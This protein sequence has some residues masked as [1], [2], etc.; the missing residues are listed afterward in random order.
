[1]DPEVL[2]DCTGTQQLYSSG[3]HLRPVRLPPPS[4]AGGLIRDFPRNV[5]GPWRVPPAFRGRG[6]FQ[7]VKRHC[8]SSRCTEDAGQLLLNLRPRLVQVNASHLSV[9][10]KKSKS[11]ITMMIDRWI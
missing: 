1:M 11:I 5:A 9:M 6:R 8:Y 4:L 3:R 7:Y 10:T 2:S